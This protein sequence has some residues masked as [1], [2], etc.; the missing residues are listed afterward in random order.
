MELEKKVEML[1]WYAQ[2]WYASSQAD[3][4]H[5][6]VFRAQG[7]G[8]FADKCAE[9]AAEELEE[10]KACTKRV[11]ELGG[12]PVFGC[13]DQPL[14]D[15]V[16]DLLEDW[17]DGFER[18]DGVGKLNEFAAALSDDAITRKLVEGFVECESEHCAWVNRDLKIIEKIG[19]DAYL[20]EMMDI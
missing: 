11:V 12:K 8:K 16:K 10:A 19:Y 2:A 18:E 7:Y 3:A 6:A 20:T 17:A 5:E 15:D 4:I 13:I 1:N 14:F 9:E